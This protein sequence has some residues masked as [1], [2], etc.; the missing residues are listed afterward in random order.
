MAAAL[1]AVAVLVQAVVAAA[2]AARYV[3][4]RVYYHYC[5]SFL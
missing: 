2:F 4:A 5:C 1:P 3:V